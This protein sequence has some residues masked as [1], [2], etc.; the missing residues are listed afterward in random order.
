MDALTGACVRKFSGTAGKRGS[1]KLA[2][3]DDACTA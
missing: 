2:M 1:V 3:L